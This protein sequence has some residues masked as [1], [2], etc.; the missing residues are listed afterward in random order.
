MHAFYF[1]DS[2]KRLFGAYHAPGGD[3]VRRE[4]VVLC[5]PFGHEYIR[6]HRTFR[7]LAMELSD[8][9]YHVL[10]FDYYG[11]G[12][13]A[14]GASEGSI[15]QWLDDVRTAIEELQATA[16]ITRVSLVG[17]R[18]GATLAAL[19][20]VDRDD[21][22]RLVLWDPVIDG[23]RYLETIETV[24]REWLDGRPLMKTPGRGAVPEELIGFPLSGLLREQFCAIDLRTISPWT[25]RSVVE[26]VTDE[27][28]LRGAGGP[29]SLRAGA[30]TLVPAACQWRHPGSVHTAL[31]A[32][33][34][35][36]AIANI[37]AESPTA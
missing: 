35:V 19:A 2:R 22:E 26:L 6:A 34:V 11:C 12:D 1:G 8:R 9:G 30:R 17:S 15:A 3:V 13:S 28:D 29:G 31:R 5:Y 4:G 36:Q 37:F 25:A 18:V 7:T 33:E 10:R 20:H 32:H 24:E 23:R 21:I 27:G 16:D 14:G